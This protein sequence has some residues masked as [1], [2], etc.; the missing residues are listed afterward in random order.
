[1]NK[2]IYFHGCM[3]AG[4]SAKIL[5]LIHEFHEQN[6]NI[7]A[8]KPLMSARNSKNKITDRAGESYPADIIEQKDKWDGEFEARVANKIKH[9][10]HLDLVVAD[11]AQF[12]EPKHIKQLKHIVHHYFPT[13]T[14]M[15]FGLLKT[16]QNKLFPTSKWL[17][18]NCDDLREIKST[19]FWCNRKATSNLRLNNK[20]PVY[21]GDLVQIGGNDNYKSVC[22]Y[23]YHHPVLGGIKYESKI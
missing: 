5:S 7:L 21:K 4:K 18:E 13:T 6:K 23:H 9:L 11:E 10:F 14:I 20:K 16:F 17:V 3:N 22:T 8:I 1:M 19:C 12:L 2:L 15:L